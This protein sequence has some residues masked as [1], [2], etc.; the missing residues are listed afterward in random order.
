M[1]ASRVHELFVHEVGLRRR[2]LVCRPIRGEGASAAHPRREARRRLPRVVSLV[3]AIGDRYIFRYIYGRY[4]ALDP[5]PGSCTPLQVRYTPLQ[6]GPLISAACTPLGAPPSSS[7][8]LRFGQIQ[9]RGG[10]VSK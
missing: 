2:A 9:G 1:S 6:V 8:L 5:P 10:G 7:Q 4:M 3:I